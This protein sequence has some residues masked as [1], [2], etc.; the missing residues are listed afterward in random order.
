MNT[1]ASMIL[2]AN[3]TALP[4]SW[5]EK[6]FQKMEDRYGSLWADRYG[7]FPRKRVMDT[8]AEDLA[9]FTGNEIRIGLDA[10]KSLKF[11]PTLPEFINLCRPIIDI[12][13]EWVEA[14]EQMRIRLQGMQ[15][16]RW[17]R[18]QLYWAAVAI[19]YYDL[20]SNSWDQIKTRWGNAIANAKSEPIPEYH[21]QL[22]S[23]GKQSI[24]REEAEKRVKSLNVT[25]GDGD[26]DYKAWAQRILKNPNSFPSVSVKFANEAMG[27]A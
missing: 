20:N 25:L 4:D 1:T 23:P 7:N 21:A 14:C 26:I 13:A 17:S 18:P 10:S 9:G 15:Q 8:W 6:L 11:P 2:P 3:A 22:P 5:M 16:D 12:R 24:S 19:G 27:H